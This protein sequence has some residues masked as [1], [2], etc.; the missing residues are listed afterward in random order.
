MLS[1][2]AKVFVVTLPLTLTG[3]L[4]GAEPAACIDAIACAEQPNWVCCQTVSDGDCEGFGLDRCN[5]RA[6]DNPFEWECFLLD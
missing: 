3:M 6:T 1:R 2:L 5:Q 4:S